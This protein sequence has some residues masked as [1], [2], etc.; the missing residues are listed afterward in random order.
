M[1]GQGA[2]TVLQNPVVLLIRPTSLDKVPHTVNLYPHKGKMIS[3]SCSARFKV[4]FTMEGLPPC[5]IV[6]NRCST[7]ELK[8]SS[9]YRHVGPQTPNIKA[10]HPLG[11]ENRVSSGSE[12]Y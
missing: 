10:L 2:Y 11:R 5:C 4:S 1:L 6:S 9:Y 8:G 3:L 12:N 7:T